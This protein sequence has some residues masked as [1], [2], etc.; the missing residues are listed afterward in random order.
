M[1]HRW[2]DYND[3]RREKMVKKNIGTFVLVMLIVG[4]IDSIRNLPATAM[5]G[6]SLIFFFLI[7]TAL[8]LIPVAWVS[9][10]LT[11]HWPNENG[12]Y[13]WVRIAVGNKLA[14]FTI[15]LQWINT[16]VW[17]PTI[18]SFIAGTAAILIDPHLANNKIYLVC[19]IISVFW[20]MTLINLKGL[21]ISAK[22]AS[23]CAVFGMIIPMALIIIMGLLWL[24]LGKPMHVHI[25]THAL[26]PNFHQSSNWIS[27]TAIM[28]SFLGMELA[29]VHVK[30]IKDAKS[31][32][33]QALF[34]AAIIIMITMLLGA[35]SIMFVIPKNQIN[36]VD[37]VMQA[38]N[39]FLSAYH[40]HALLAVL[41][42]M[43]L[44]GSLGGMI[45]WIIS[46]AKGM[47][48]AGKNGFLPK[49]MCKLNKNEV[50]GNLL[51]TQAVLV[52]FVCLAF[53]LMP[54]VNGS[55]WLLT[56][57]STQLYMFMYVLMFIAGGVLAVKFIPKL[58]LKMLFAA[59]L[60]LL[61]CGITIIVGFF[62]PVSIIDVGGFWHYEITF[63]IGI[64][65]MLLPVLFFYGYRYKKC[66]DV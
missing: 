22:F 21:E 4:S 8:F 63:I 44:V 1:P 56:D 10:Q 45:N 25:S 12:V 61:G 34:Y 31:K 47:L 62:P 7:S 64:V 19:I 58:K 38:F 43:L 46:P 59:V 41:T 52:T 50:A 53:L 42:V 6:S 28:T 26:L 36:L 66:V 2:T 29:T 30:Q 15:W 5:F 14:F 55:Y 33:T 16:V 37:G 27:L 17:Y 57:L 54:G 51:I 20:I 9:A 35:F 48:I 18:L 24:F 13:D 60:G 3:S 40:L 11:R 32:M 65:L 49:F 23:F 39:L